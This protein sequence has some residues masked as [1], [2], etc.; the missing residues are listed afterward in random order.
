[1]GFI[2][3]YSV[4]ALVGC[5]VKLLLGQIYSLAEE[6]STR[7][8]RSGRAKVSIFSEGSRVKEK[9]DSLNWISAPG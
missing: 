2:V 6:N 5:I 8:P 7:M 9:S 4:K 1:M 3:F